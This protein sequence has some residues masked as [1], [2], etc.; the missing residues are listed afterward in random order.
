MYESYFGLKKKPF[1]LVPNPDFLYLG[2]TQKKALTY[3]TYAVQE[4]IGFLLLTGEVGSGKT[5]LLRDFTNK[6]DRH[7]T[8]AKVFNTKVNF[9]QLIAMINDDFGLDTTGKDRVALLKDLY[10][11]LAGEH[12]KGR[13]PILIIDE[14]QNLEAS[15]LEDVRMLSNLETQDA[16][17]LQIILAGQPE[18]AATLALPELR[19]LRQRISIVCH[20]SPL[21]RQECEEYIFHRLAVAGNRDALRFLPEAMDGIHS[22]S[23]GIPRLV[24]IICNFLLLTAYAEGVR[25][26]GRDMVDDVVKD[27]RNDA[28]SANGNGVDAVAR[29]RALLQALGAAAAPE[30]REQH[31]AAMPAMGP[32]ECER[33]I[34][35]LLKDIS[36]RLAALEKHQ[37]LAMEKEREDK[38]LYQQSLEAA[39]TDKEKALFVLDQ[40]KSRIDRLEKQ[41]LQ[42]AEHDRHPNGGGNHSTTSAPGKPQ[43]GEAGKKGLVSRIIG[44]LS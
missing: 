39:K 31:D 12:A 10:H 35:L 14:A 6:L 27:L 44:G 40:V 33:K 24:N 18:L 36:L 2:A 30:M 29:K 4:K 28:V 7:A 32:S 38:K 9:E 19:Q 13:M 37:V 20:L 22:F 15:V 11:F 42:S 1:E 16:K 34:L 21:S 8:L 17:L 41:R 43:Q 3:L 25:E 26:V 5:T 23:S